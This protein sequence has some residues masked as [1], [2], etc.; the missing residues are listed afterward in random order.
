MKNQPYYLP[1]SPEYAPGP[2]G[3][4]ST[5]AVQDPLTA[6]V[7]GKVRILA[8]TIDQI[9]DEIEERQNLG[10][11]VMKEIVM[12][13]SDLKEP[14]Y[15]VAPFGSSPLTVGDPRRRAAIEKALLTLETEHRRE[16]VATWKDVAGLKRELREIA[17]EYEEEKNRARVMSV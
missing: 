7:T 10:E 4:K 8:T 13:M 14:L 11:K 3:A 15:Q 17:R 1:V 16:E 12:R 2:S 9:V 6:F 5:S